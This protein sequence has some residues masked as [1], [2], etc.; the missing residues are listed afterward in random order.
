MAD[1]QDQKT[2]EYTEKKLVQNF[3]LRKNLKL[4]TIMNLIL[5]NL[6]ALFLLLLRNYYFSNILSIFS[7]IYFSCSFFSFFL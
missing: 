1:D 3:D 6:Q 5:R 7:T 2:W 4:A